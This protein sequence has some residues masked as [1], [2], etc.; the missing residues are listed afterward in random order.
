MQPHASKPLGAYQISILMGS[1]WC[2]YP[3]HPMRHLVNKKGHGQRQPWW[4]AQLVDALVWEFTEV[5][6]SNLSCPLS[7]LCLLR[8]WE[9]KFS[10]L[11]LLDYP[12][13]QKSSHFLRRDP[14]ISRPLLWRDPPFIGPFITMRP[15]L[16]WAL[17]YEKAHP[18]SSCL[19]WLCPPLRGP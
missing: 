16:Y 4:L 7:P 1:Y 12:S 18:L 2:P 10:S 9:T 14:P 6:R 3:I 8:S 13:L 11:N 17:Y 19:G 15:S 5:S